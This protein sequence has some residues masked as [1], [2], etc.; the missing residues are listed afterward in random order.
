MKAEEPGF[1]IFD[2]LNSVNESEYDVKREDQYL[3]NMIEMKSENVK[4]EHHEFMN[5]NPQMKM[6]DSQVEYEDLEHHPQIHDDVNVLLNCFR[7]DS[8][9]FQRMNLTL[10]VVRNNIANSMGPMNL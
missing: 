10:N 4:E 2:R 5:I 9:S 3:M 7:N 8:S 6:E 1:D